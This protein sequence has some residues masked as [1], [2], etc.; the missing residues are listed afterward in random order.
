MVPSRICR[1][2]AI[3]DEGNVEGEDVNVGSVGGVYSVVEDRAEVKGVLK[4]LVRDRSEERR[5]G[6]TVFNASKRVES[7]VGERVKKSVNHQHLRL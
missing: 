6:S 4:H 7:E 3:M 1:P 5:L 2:P